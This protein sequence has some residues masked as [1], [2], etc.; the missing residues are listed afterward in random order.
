MDA[1]V[2]QYQDY[3]GGD[4][5]FELDF[6]SNSSIFD[7]D[8]VITDWSG[9]AYEFSFV[10]GKPAVFVDTLMKVNNPEYEK[11]G[12]EPLEISLRDQVGIRLDPKHLEGTYEKLQFLFEQQEEY[13]KQNLELRDRYI[14]N[15]GHSGE[16]AGKYIISSLKEKAQKR[17]NE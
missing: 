16:V 13:Q 14:A 15:F 2:N 3:S 1:I 12:I 7:S 11:L 5:K 8:V 9:T 6:T 10:T 4:L 17:K